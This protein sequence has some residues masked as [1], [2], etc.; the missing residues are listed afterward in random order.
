MYNQSGEHDQ[1]SDNYNQQ[2]NLLN[3]T[4]LNNL[5]DSNAES[6][7]H[8]YEWKS[9]NMMIMNHVNELMSVYNSNIANNTTTTNSIGGTT[10]TMVSG[11]QMNNCNTEIN[12]NTPVITVNDNERLNQDSHHGEHQFNKLLHIN[13]NFMEPPSYLFTSLVCSRNS[14]DFKD[15]ISH[16]N[17]I[18]VSTPGLHDHT[19]FESSHSLSTIPTASSSIFSGM[20]QHIVLPPT[21][22]QLIT[23]SACTSTAETSGL[24]HECK[25]FNSTGKHHSETSDELMNIT[26]SCSPSSST[27]ILSQL[28]GFNEG[29][30]MSGMDYLQG[31]RSNESLNTTVLVNNTGNNNNNNNN[32]STNNA[33]IPGTGEYPSA[34]DLEIFAKM[35]KQRRIKLG[36]TQADVGLALGTLYGNVFSQT[37]ICRFEALQLSFKNMCKLKPL[38]Q[39]WLH[40][41]DCSTGTTNNLDKITTQGRKRKKRTSIEIGVKGILEN[42]F[43][44]QPKPL[45]QDIIQLADVLGLEKEVVRVWFCNRRQKQK[46]LNPLLLGSGLNSNEDSTCGSMNNDDSYDDDDDDDEADGE[47][48]EDEVDNDLVEEE[49]HGTGVCHN[50]DHLNGVIKEKQTGNHLQDKHQLSSD[51]KSDADYRKSENILE[52]VCN[53]Q[54]LKRN[55]IKRSRRRLNQSLTP[56]NFNCNFINDQSSVNSVHN[57]HGISSCSSSSLPTSSALLPSLHSTFCASNSNQLFPSHYPSYSSTLLHNL[58]FHNTKQ[59]LFNPDNL[60]QK[61]PHIFPDNHSVIRNSNNSN[62]ANGFLGLQ[63]KSFYTPNNPVCDPS[64]LINDGHSGDSSIVDYVPTEQTTNNSFMLSNLNFNQQHSNVM[65]SSAIHDGYAHDLMNYN[66]RLELPCLSTGSTGQIASNETPTYHENIDQS[67]VL[68]DTSSITTN[69]VDDL[70]NY[71]PGIGMSIEGYN[72]DHSALISNIFMHTKN[73]TCISDPCSVTDSLFIY[74]SSHQQHVYTLIHKWR[75]LTPEYLLIFNQV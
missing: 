14:E 74:P 58:P 70:T 25:L 24:I 72:S 33:I 62:T 56:I 75:E 18:P 46:R 69:C 60:L 15:S 27:C 5:P 57:L 49:S 21:S 37:T 68:N 48:E 66:S 4:N 45:A 28:P 43:I 53:N 44:K 41:A 10:D 52:N 30:I 73:T 67:G 11:T 55:S 64:G 2:V 40:E 23:S 17:S 50:G 20:L 31:V 26:G 3:L 13:P 42:H 59:N 7:F 34:D 35:F 22:I 51:S 19:S 36:Y 39:K 16:N 9:S 61:Y 1:E 63:L 29:V 12:N 6:A 47:E 32:N 8:K 71:S 38:L 54:S 65:S